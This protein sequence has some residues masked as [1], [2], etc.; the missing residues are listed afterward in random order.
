LNVKLRSQKKKNYV[1][2]LFIAVYSFEASHGAQL[3][4]MFKSAKF[5][6]QIEVRLHVALWGQPKS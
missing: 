5:W 3:H 4:T 1:L 6:L 2:I